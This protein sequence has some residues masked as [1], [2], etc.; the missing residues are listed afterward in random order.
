MATSLRTPRIFISHSHR[1][2]DFGLQLIEDLR[3]VI[4]DESAV[5]YDS[6]GGLHGGDVWWRE[7]IKELKQRNIFIVILSPNSVRSYYVKEEIEKARI[8]HIHRRM[9]IIP[10]LYQKCRIPD[11]LETIQIV[12]FVDKTYKDAFQ[13]LMIALKL[14][15]KILSVTKSSY[16][17]TSN[18]PK[19][20][21]LA[22]EVETAYQA[23]DW[24]RVIEQVNMITNHYP[25]TMHPSMYLMQGWAYYFTKQPNLALEA[26]KKG[27]KLVKNPQGQLSLLSQ[28]IARPVSEDHLSETFAH[29]SS[30]STERSPDN[31]QIVERS[32]QPTTLEAKPPK[33]QSLEERLTDIQVQREQLKLQKERFE[34]EKELMIFAFEL[35][36]RMAHVINDADKTT[37][38]MLL[39]AFLPRFS[40]LENER[41]EEE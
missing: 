38:A 20:G 17:D 37:K 13:E 19:V 28:Y 25:E 24:I 39:R 34:I 27:I 31:K 22:Q 30:L 14:S 7:I 41:E 2:N 5:W 21:F 26:L 18:E 16:A 8:R 11:D 32:D 4:G 33:I 1:D 10:V 36:E 35:S 29:L 3:Q 23:H 40:F 9:K 15:S 12:S 6:K